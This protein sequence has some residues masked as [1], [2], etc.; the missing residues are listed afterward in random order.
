MIEEELSIAQKE[1]VDCEIEILNKDL[2][3]LDMSIL[4]TKI[5]V[6]VTDGYRNVVAQFVK[7][8]APS[9]WYSL[10]TGDLANGKIEF[11]ILSSITQF[12][13]PGKYYAEVLVRYASGAHPD[14]NYY[15]VA[16]DAPKYL[17]TIYESQINKI[18]SLP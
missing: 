15:D 14:D 2:S 10:E 13:K 1:D 12:L 11:K 17:F 9:G 18:T 3:A 8:T 5:Y 7:G 16:P 4:G 6:V